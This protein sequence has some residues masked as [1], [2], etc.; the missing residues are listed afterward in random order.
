M[1]KFIIDADDEM[2]KLIRE[3]VK[4]ALVAMSR[5]EMKAQVDEGIRRARGPGVETMDTL[6]R[7]SLD[8]AILSQVVRQL[9]GFNVASEAREMVRARLTKEIDLVVTRKVDEAMQK[10]DVEALVRQALG[11]ITIQAKAPEQAA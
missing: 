10:V 9:A 3:E 1:F 7:N 8:R 6:V 11:T 5:E 2:R 4:G